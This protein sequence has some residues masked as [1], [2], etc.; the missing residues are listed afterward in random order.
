ML[1]MQRKV[2]SSW[3]KG[4]S[5][6]ICIK[7]LHKS[8]KCHPQHMANLTHIPVFHRVRYEL[9]CLHPHKEKTS[10]LK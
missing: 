5:V 6:L 8:F 7:L 1:S 3:L 10:S 9:R 4:I 2:Q